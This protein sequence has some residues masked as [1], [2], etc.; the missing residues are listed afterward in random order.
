MLF[1]LPYVRINFEFCNIF[2]VYAPRLDSL[3]GAV[4]LWLFF[5]L[6]DGITFL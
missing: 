2:V 3:K 6:L 4:S 5:V 1:L